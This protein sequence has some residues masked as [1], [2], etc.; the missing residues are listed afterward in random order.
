MR[1]ATIDELCLE[2]NRV[3]RMDDISELHSPMTRYAVDV[4][5]KVSIEKLS[6]PVFKKK[7]IK[8]GFF[9]LPDDCIRLITVLDKHYSI[10]QVDVSSVGLVNNMNLGLQYSLNMNQVSVRGCLSSDEVIVH[11]MSLPMCEGTNELMITE[12]IYS[13]ILNYA[14][15][16]ELRILSTRKEKQYMAAS[17]ISFKVDA[18]Q[19]MDEARAELNRFTTGDY[20][21]IFNEVMTIKKQNPELTSY[22]YLGHGLG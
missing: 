5:K 3:L 13:A 19:L 9:S 20:L 7:I 11:Y 6:I 17:A 21:R 16:N 8:N 15:F 18:N 1:F 2:A 22:H 10:P 14:L 12:S 4:I